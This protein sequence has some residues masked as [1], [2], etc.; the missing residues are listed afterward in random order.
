[1]R[2]S[3]EILVVSCYELGRPPVGAAMPFSWLKRAGFHP[4]LRDLAVQGPQDAEI[5]RAKLIV[6]STPMH[7]ALRLGSAFAERVRRVN[8]ESKVVFHG[9]YAWLNRGHLFARDARRA[10]FVIGGEPE[11]VLVALAEALDAGGDP[12][13]IAGVSS[14]HR[15]EPPVLKRLDSPKI[16]RG[17]LP[18]LESYAR[19]K[20]DGAERFAG[21]VES[22]R[23]CKHLCRHCPIPPVYRGR[24]FGVPDEVVFDSAARQIEAGAAHLTFSDPDFL[25]GPTR[26][27]K[28]L[29]RLHREAPFLTFDFTAKIEHLIRYRHL[30]PSF[31][32]AGTI[33]VVSAAESLSER[34]LTLLDKGHSAEQIREAVR[35][36]R[37]AGISVR[38]T[39]V[40]FTPWSGLDD[41]AELLS[42]LEREGLVYSIE[43]VQLAIRLL[44]PPGSALVDFPQMRP[45]LKGIGEDGLSHR[46]EHPDPAVDRLQLRVMELVV[47]AAA[48][49]QDEALTF[50][51]VQEAL[52]A[53]REGDPEGRPVLPASPGPRAPGLS[54]N[55]F[56]C[57]EPTE[58]Q[59]SGI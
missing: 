28:I 10:D 53:I 42:F 33:F 2:D 58:T 27:L 32:R 1:M 35:A 51:R 7:T 18:G 37:R 36:C 38:P 39:W 54:E 56:C 6:V 48:D 26:A 52:R 8:P 25:N 17:E 45:H 59:L 50:A 3:G 5:A 21:V 16:D 22:T 9:L 15:R 11:E 13:A 47:K 4:T 24:F 44:V 20:V 30:L 41:Y 29:E 14:Q 23:G 34:V 43:P 40:P 19:L 49:S 46:W 57:A 55:W 12:E 31:G